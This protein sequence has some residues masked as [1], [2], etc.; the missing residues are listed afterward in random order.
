[1]K[2]RLLF[3]LA[4][5]GNSWCQA[6]SATKIDLATQA[7]NPDFSAAALTKPFRTGSSLP[8]TCSVSEVFYDTTGQPGENIQ[9]CYAPNQWIGIRAAAQLAA[10]PGIEIEQV[11]STQV[12]SA[13]TKNY[14]FYSGPGTD[15]DITGSAVTLKANCTLVGCLGVQNNWSAAQMY[16]GVLDATG[17]SRTQ[18]A[19]LGMTDPPTCAEGELFYNQGVHALKQCT[20]PNTWTALGQSPKRLAEIYLPSTI[21]VNGLATGGWQTPGSDGAVFSGASTTSTDTYGLLGFPHGRDSTAFLPLFRLPTVWDT[22]AP[23]TVI[24]DQQITQQQGGIAILEISSHCAGAGAILHPPA[25]VS[26]GPLLYSVPADQAGGLARYS[27][28]LLVTDCTP[29]DSVAVMI[30]RHG[31]APSDSFTGDFALLGAAIQWQENLR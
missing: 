22:G 9:I 4:L 7:K 11:G 28:N 5:A 3:F 19:R 1:M 15:V 6:P 17:A 2:R 23:V 20:G 8:P 21:I 10:G 13:T 12:V 25:W 16:T 29:G 26:S 18:P 31:T 24:F 27:Y 30:T 14:D